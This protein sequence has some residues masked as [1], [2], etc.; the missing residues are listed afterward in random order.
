MSA[1]SWRWRRRSAPVELA[2]LQYHGWA[3]PSAAT[4]PAADAGAACAR[5]GSHQPLSPEGRRK[6]ASSSSGSGSLSRIGPGAL[7][8]WLGSCI[9]HHCA[10]R[11]RIAVR[12]AA[13]MPPGLD[14][15]RTRR[16]PEVDL[17]RIRG[18]NRLSRLR[19]DEGAASRV[20]EKV[21]DFWR[22]P[23]GVSVTGDP[24]TPTRVS[25]SRRIG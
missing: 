9:P 19:L 5:R 8:E 4:L 24:P 18:F 1:R 14:F 2:P 12:H 7:H 6:C 3:H 23:L 16:E 20:R 21:K 10:G 15:K 25:T 11:C 13:R 22:L 17:V